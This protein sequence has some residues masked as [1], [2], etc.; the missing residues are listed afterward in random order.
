M[1][2]IQKIVAEVFIDHSTLYAMLHAGASEH[3]SINDQL[4]NIHQQGSQ[5]LVLAG[6]AQGQLIM[7]VSAAVGGQGYDP[8]GQIFLDR[9]RLSTSMPSGAVHGIALYTLATMHKNYRALPSMP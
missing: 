4:R 3:L 2:A 6:A 8:N 5:L 1:D 7:A 9:S